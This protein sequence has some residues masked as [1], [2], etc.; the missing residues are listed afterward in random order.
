[1]FGAGPGMGPG[2]VGPYNPYARGRPFGM[3]P[4]G[5]GMMGMGPMGAMG[6]GMGK[7]NFA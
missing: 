6:M 4:G 2:A 3:G 7:Q 1:M 5:P